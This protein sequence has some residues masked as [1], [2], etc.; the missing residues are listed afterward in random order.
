MD[1]RSFLRLAAF[2][3]A[4]SGTG[5]KAA[6]QATDYS[7]FS[8]SDA[9]KFDSIVKKYST[10]KY[11]KMKIGDLI[12]AIAQEFL[13]TPYV[14]G[15]LEVAQSE[16]CV[17]NLNGLDCV[18]FYENALAFARI[19]KQNKKTEV[20]FRNELIRL[21]YRAGIIEDYVSRLHYTSDWI[22]DNVLKGVVQDI[23]P[24]FK[25]LKAVNEVGF[26]SA[27]PKYYKQLSNNEDFVARIEE[28]ERNLNMVRK[29]FVPQNS[30]PE[31]EKELKSGDIIAIATSVKG[32]DYSHTGIIV[33]VK[34]EARFMHASTKE[35]KVILDNR[36]SDYLKANNKAIGITIARPLE[37]K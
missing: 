31:I 4:F 6:L 26:M 21:R 2:A 28:I 11:R 7:K 16:S 19:I 30:V 36:I 33:R 25:P 3:V 27:N 37:I 9:I 5:L 22:N 12:A 20:D 18:T 15:T 8:E 34:K 13:G 1:R 32:L 17:L 29:V 35:K 24:N 23:T 10:P 14:G